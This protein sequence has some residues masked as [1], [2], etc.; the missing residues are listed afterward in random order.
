MRKTSFLSNCK[1]VQKL[2]RIDKKFFRADSMRF[3]LGSSRKTAGIL[4]YFKVFA[5]QSRGK[6]SAVQPEKIF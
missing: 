5:V 2:G 6:R 3:F 1:K 4:M